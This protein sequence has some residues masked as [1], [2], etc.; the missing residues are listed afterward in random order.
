MN[1]PL[2]TDGSQRAP[3][4]G[5]RLPVQAAVV[6]AGFLLGE[7]EHRLN[8]AAEVH[9]AKCDVVNVAAEHVGREV[10]LEGEQRHRREVVEDDDGL[11]DEHH[12]EGSLLQ[13]VHLVSAGSRPSQRPQYG[14]V[15]EHHK[16]ERCQYHRREDLLEVED[17]ARAF[18]SSVGERD[19]PDAEGENGS[20]LALL[21]LGEGDGMDHG[22]VAV[23]AD[24]GEEER[25]GVFNAVEEAQDVPGAA[26]GEEDDVCQLKR[27][28]EAEER[29]QNRQV[30]NE[31]I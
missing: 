25:R 8:A 20:V 10:V 28:D 19:Q 31:D 12:L 5:G 27:G 6:A 7:V 23:Q 26:A 1:F 22:H 18:R 17:V 4:L 13:R 3:L 29:V 30:E 2:Q 16:G 15:A 11:D 21:E 9:Q 24:A 14:S